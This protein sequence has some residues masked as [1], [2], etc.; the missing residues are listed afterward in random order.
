MAQLA[1]GYSGQH[2]SRARS[3]ACMH[4]FLKAGRLT[5]TR[6]RALLQTPLSPRRAMF[7]KESRGGSLDTQ[8][9]KGVIVTDSNEEWGFWVRQLDWLWPAFE[10]SGGASNAMRVWRSTTAPN[11]LLLLLL[12]RRVQPTMVM[13]MVAEMKR[14]RVSYLP[15]SMLLPPMRVPLLVCLYLCLCILVSLTRPSVH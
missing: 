15:T 10:P 9:P 5:A 8:L 4:A 12:G 3:L 2:G 1:R 11:M 6:V 7:R 14:R 13:V